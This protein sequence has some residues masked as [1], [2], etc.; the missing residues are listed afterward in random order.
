MSDVGD[1]DKI[2]TFLEL[3][4]TSEGLE[5]FLNIKKCYDGNMELF[6]D[7][8]FDYLSM[9]STDTISADDNL[10]DKFF[11]YYKNMMTLQSESEFL[12]QFARYA[13]YYL[14]LNFEYVKDENLKHWVSIINKYEG[15]IAYPFLMEVLD[16]FEHGR[17]EMKD[18]NDMAL[19]VVNLLKNSN[20]EDSMIRYEFS[21]LGMRV[22]EML[23]VDSSELLNKKAV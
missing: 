14:M 18:L 12:E 15:K 20:R 22:N 8:I 7:F 1:L 9:Q 4:L 23:T 19:M 6:E 13:K 3:E 2:F 21:Q 10:Y 16:D 11:L 5:F 17:I